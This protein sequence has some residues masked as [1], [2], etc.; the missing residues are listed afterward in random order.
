MNVLGWN[1]R[2]ICINVL[3]DSTCPVFYILFNLKD[4]LYLELSKF[5]YKQYVELKILY[6]ILKLQFFGLAR[7][8]H[9]TYPCATIVYLALTYMPVIRP[10][11][12][13]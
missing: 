8:P 5:T 13:T 12:Q 7:D 1:G 10:N 6:M 2:G 4:L 3:E 9:G 11:F